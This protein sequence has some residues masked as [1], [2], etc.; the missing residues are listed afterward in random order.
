[1]SLE[2]F[3][4]AYGEFGSSLHLEGRLGSATIEDGADYK[5]GRRQHHREGPT[6]AGRRCAGGF[7]C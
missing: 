1:M 4:A 2:A 3:D 6:A 5:D 7:P